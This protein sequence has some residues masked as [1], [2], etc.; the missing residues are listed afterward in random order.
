MSLAAVGL[1]PGVLE[2]FEV[3][4]QSGSS[5][6]R[7]VRVERGFAS[8]ILETG[9]G[10]FHVPKSLTRTPDQS[11]VTGDWVVLDESRKVVGGVLP[12][13]SCFS[14][15]AAGK[16]D[17]EQ[18]VAANV[19]LVFVLMGLDGDFNLRRL[20]RY[21]TISSESGARCV[22]LLTKASLCAETEARCEEVQRVAQDAPV[23]AIDVITGIGT[24][25]PRLYLLEGVTA[26][27]VGSSG[28][29]KSTLANFL[30]G[31]LVAR[32]AAVRVHDE[33]GKHTTSRRELFLLPEGGVVIDTPGMREL[34]LWGE[35]SS[36]DAAFADVLEHANAC[37]F[38]DCR[39]EAEPGCA[40]GLALESGELDAARFASYR[41]LSAELEAREKRRR[42][43]KGSDRPP[44][45]SRR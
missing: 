27:L 28:V 34:A 23:H 5:L 10:S 32:T 35:S 24:D 3:A 2:A 31:A 9:E 14:R 20:E 1:R 29:G 18:I 7:V 8:V 41:N 40:V 44:R 22:V 15:K 4:R 42:P 11:P 13:W 26:A 45:S 17:E 36:I 39:H 43:A 30:M 16:R 38:S 25:A 6:G 19:D 21:L 37:R 33:R 12:R